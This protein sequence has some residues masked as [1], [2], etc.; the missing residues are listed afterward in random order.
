[1]DGLSRKLLESLP[2]AEGVLALL[3]W[4]TDESALEDLFAR[5]RGRSYASV[6]SFSVMVQLIADALL[7]HRGSGRQALI[8][9]AERGDL[10]ASLQA[11][12]GKLRRIPVGLSN[13]FLAGVT[14]R[15]QQVFPPAAQQPLAASLE[16]FDVIVIDGKK[17]KHAAKR[18]KPARAYAGTPLGGKGLAALNL[19]SGLIIA[20]NAHLDG[21]TNDAPL[22][23]GLLPQVRERMEQP[24]L[25]VAD[26]QFCDLVQTRRFQEEE[27]HFLVRYHPKNR[28][29]PALEPS[30]RCGV[31]AQQRSYRE[32]WGWLGAPSNKQRLFVRRVTLT[33]PGEDD[34]ILVT[35]LLEADQF[36][37]GDLLETYRLRWSI[38]RVFQ[39]VTEVFH[40][41][42]LISSSPQGTIF[43]CAF[44]MVLYNLIQVMRGYLASAQQR[45]SSTISSELLFYDIH[46][47]LI[48]LHTVAERSRLSVSLPCFPTAV[49]LMHH[50]TILFQNEWKDRWLKSPPKKKPKSTAAKKPIAGGHTSI[51]RILRDAE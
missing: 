12:Y 34:L 5:H 33:R 44:C 14:D 17:I 25:F 32:E 28:F 47:E 1:M 21:E 35:D 39:Q 3:A 49:E 42:R 22:I 6:L 48:A 20:M 24:R 46:R 45:P 37:A 40:L 41:E 26:S 13:G 38:E 16:R 15:L 11:A 19:R 2:L 9:G 51:Y 30:P 10:E 23:P 43:Q 31:D 8:R 27:D 4:A 50:L 29:D 36:P 7:E 18:L